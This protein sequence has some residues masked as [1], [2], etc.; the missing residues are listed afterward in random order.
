MG[1]TA[2]QARYIGKLLYV[3]GIT[4]SKVCNDL[5]INI[6]SRPMDLSIAD[7]DRVIKTLLPLQSIHGYTKGD[8][9]KA[10]PFNPPTL[11]EKAKEEPKQ[12]ETLPQ[13]EIKKVLGQHEKAATLDKLVS[14][15]VNVYLKGPAGS[16]KTT[17]ALHAAKRIGMEHRFYPMSVG[18]QTSKS[19]LFGY[20]DANGHF[21]KT[22]LFFAY[23]EGGVFL[24]DEVDAG[25]P[26]IFTGINA[27][28]ANSVCSFPDG[29]VYT[30][31]PDFICIAAANTFGTGADAMYVGR[32]QLDAAT[33]DRF[34]VL[35]WPYDEQFE[36]HLTVEQF[37]NTPLTNKWIMH[38]QKVR[39]IVSNLK[40]R[41]VISPRATLNGALL[42]Q[43]GFGWEDVQNLSLYRA[44]STD[45]RRKI[46]SSL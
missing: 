39:A 35:D 5:G 45:D 23:T 29:K 22:A 38:V 20:M 26:G 37:G 36:K 33:L 9:P 41:I 2:K 25:N 34:I 24:L 31:H 12:I 15:R 16:G 13:V 17:A 3:K 8:E 27:L 44:C 46:E 40:L 6:P 42:L 32:Q 10:K 21:V 28:L 11:E 14:L 7:A 1:A 19:D 43:N 18:P 30:K 4:L